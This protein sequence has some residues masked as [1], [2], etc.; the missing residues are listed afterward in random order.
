MGR[1]MNRAILVLMA[2]V[3][4]AG[5]SKDIPSSSTLRLSDMVKLVITDIR[6]TDDASTAPGNVEMK[7]T[8]ANTINDDLQLFFLGKKYQ[9]AGSFRLVYA[10]QEYVASEKL[11]GDPQ[12]DVMP[13]GWGILPPGASTDFDLCFD[14]E[15]EQAR[16]LLADPTDLSLVMYVMG[17]ERAGKYTELIGNATRL[18]GQWE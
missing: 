16:K 1:T 9:S 2:G 11:S 14:I 15:P 4:M 18:D 17:I 5:C 13:A 3:L 12:Y 7:V 8:V 6:E 10:G